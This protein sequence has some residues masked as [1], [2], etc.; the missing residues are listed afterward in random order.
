MR[1]EALSGFLNGLL[2]S[3]ES[4]STTATTLSGAISRYGLPMRCPGLQWNW[5][6][7]RRRLQT[8][9]D[10]VHAFQ[11]RRLPG[12]DFENHAVGLIDPGLVVAD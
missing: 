12:V 2:R 7:I 10:V 6:A 9:I 1:R 3:G 5:S 8:V 4:V 11:R